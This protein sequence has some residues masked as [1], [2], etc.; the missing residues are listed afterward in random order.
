MKHA[1]CRIHG[2]LIK[3]L[4]VNARN[5][6]SEIMVRVENCSGSGMGQCSPIGFGSAQAMHFAFLQLCLVFMPSAFI[7][8][9]G[10]N[11]A[12]QTSTPVFI[13]NAK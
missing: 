4:T 10:E 8:R 7:K 5:V 1:L 2:H 11:L 6:I 3:L 13:L 12:Y 9:S